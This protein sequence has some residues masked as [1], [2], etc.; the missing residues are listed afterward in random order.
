MAADA[1]TLDSWGVYST[2]RSSGSH[3]AGATRDSLRGGHPRA[4]FLTAVPGWAGRLACTAGVALL[5]SSA[6]SAT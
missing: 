4:V 3:P 2:P 1:R 6:A 5:A